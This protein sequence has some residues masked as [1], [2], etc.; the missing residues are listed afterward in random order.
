M[1]LSPAKPDTYDVPCLHPEVVAVTRAALLPHKEARG[2]HCVVP[3]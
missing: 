2:C 3:G 1:V